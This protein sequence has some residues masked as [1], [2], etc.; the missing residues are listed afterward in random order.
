MLNPCEIY[1][2]AKNNYGLGYEKTPNVLKTRYIL[3]KIAS[4]LEDKSKG[5]YDPSG[6]QKEVENFFLDPESGFN[7]KHDQQAKEQAY[8]TTRQILRYVNSVKCS[9]A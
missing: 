6:L 9:T 4:L 8:D 2:K 1:N 3:D 5:V 7:W